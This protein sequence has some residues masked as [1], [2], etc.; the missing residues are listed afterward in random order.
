MLKVQRLETLRLYNPLPG[1]PQYTG[2][3]AQTL[4][5]KDHNIDISEDTIVVPQ[6]SWRCTPT[7]VIGAQIPLLDNHPD[8][9]STLANLQPPTSATDF[10]TKR[11][12]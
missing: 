9:S 8:G 1:V 6:T 4:R 11:C 3:Q 10:L 7:L 5:V 12:W 2:I